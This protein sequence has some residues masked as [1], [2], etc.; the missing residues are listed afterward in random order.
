MLKFANQNYRDPFIIKKRFHIISFFLLN[1]QLV[2]T[3]A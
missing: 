2:I 1:R 3:G